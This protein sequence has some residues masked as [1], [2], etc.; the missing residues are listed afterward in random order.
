M[1]FAGLEKAL[2]LDHRIA[3]YVPGTNGVSEAADNAA[4][5]AAVAAQLS[6]FFGGASAQP[7]R[8]FWT[9]AAGDLVEEKTVVVYANCTGEQLQQHGP[10]IIETAEQI[11]RDLQQEAVSVE[12]DGILYII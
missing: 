6:G 8:G 12:I 7:I 3:V 1:K 5:V 2:K 10:A 11:K 9:S 4:T